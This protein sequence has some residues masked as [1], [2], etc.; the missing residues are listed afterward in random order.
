M[1][2]FVA[3]CVAAIALAAIGGTVLNYF[4]V[5]AKV[6]FSTNAVRPPSGLSPSS[7]AEGKLSAE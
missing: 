5:P 6:A 1:R 4:Q 2:S 3:A 7:L